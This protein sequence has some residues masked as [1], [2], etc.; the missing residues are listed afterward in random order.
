MPLLGVFQVHCN[1]FLYSTFQIV[2]L[3]QGKCYRDK[4]SV[5]VEPFDVIT[6]TFYQR[7]KIFVSKGNA[8]H[9]VLSERFFSQWD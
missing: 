4:G 8:V 2:S 1:I 7:N 9:T 3:E 6:S 5:Q